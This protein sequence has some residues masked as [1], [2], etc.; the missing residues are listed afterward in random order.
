MFRKVKKLWALLKY[1]FTDEDNLFLHLLEMKAYETLEACFNLDVSMTE[2]VEDFIFHIQSYYDIEE[3]LIETR[4]PQFKGKDIAKV[5]KE[6]KEGK[7]NE[8][9]TD[10]LI[11]FTENVERQRAVERD[12]ILE[13]AKDLTFGFRF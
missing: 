1:F 2:E 10:D 11:I 7:L 4:F 13:H 8:K 5:M 3:S 9:E 12:I 6:Y